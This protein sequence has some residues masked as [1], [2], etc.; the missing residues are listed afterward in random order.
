MITMTVVIVGETAEDIRIAI[1]DVAEHAE[2][3][4]IREMPYI[5]IDQHCMADITIDVVEKSV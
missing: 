5:D 4:D 1:N 3:N 2:Y